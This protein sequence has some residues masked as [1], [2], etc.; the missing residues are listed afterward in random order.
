MADKIV[1]KSPQSKVYVNAGAMRMRILV[2]GVGPDAIQ[3]VDA[4]TLTF[5]P[6]GAAKQF[7]P[8]RSAVVKKRKKNGDKRWAVRFEVTST[9]VIVGKKFTVAIQDDMGNTVDYGPI[10][11]VEIKSFYDGVTI[12]Y[13]LDGADITTQAD[14]FVACG[15]LPSGYIASA[16]MNNVQA[17]TVHIGS[18]NGNRFWVAWFPPLDLGTYTLQVIDSDNNSAARSNLLVH[19]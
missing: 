12:V 18:M 1:V 19:G 3:S 15:D 10:D 9:A 7:K 6:A 2:A 5:D 11:I 16:T 8:T 14:D 4:S 13:P 17:D